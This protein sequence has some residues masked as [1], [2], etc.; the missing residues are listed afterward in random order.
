MGYTNYWN[1]PT[2]FTNEEWD[3]LCEY[4]KEVRD[5]A[6]DNISLDALYDDPKENEIIIFD[7]GK[8]GTSERFVLEKKVKTEPDYEGQDLAFNF[9]KTRKYP[10]DFYVKAVLMYCTLIKSDFSYSHD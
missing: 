6:G 4:F 10:Y 9:C 7:G 3:W 1:Q 8:G 2:D 5:A